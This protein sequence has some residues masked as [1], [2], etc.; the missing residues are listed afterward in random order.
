MK[1]LSLIIHIFWGLLAI[2]PKVVS[3]NIPSGTSRPAATPLPIPGAY[4]APVINY[5][6]TWE[7]IMPVT[8]AAT[9]TGTARKVQEVRQ[10]TLYT[11]GLNRPLQSVLKSASSSGKDIVLS[12]IYDGYGRQPISYLP[13]VQTDA[14]TNDGKFKSN[15]Y[16][17]QRL[18]MQ[19]A[20][21]NP[22]SKGESIFYNQ[23]VFEQAPSSS[24][25]KS[26][27]AG[28]SYA[29][30]GGKKNTQQ[31]NFVNTTTDSVRIWEIAAGIPV[32][33]KVYGAGQLTEA[34][35]IAENGSQVVEYSDKSGRIILRKVQLA[36][37]PGASHTGWLCT[38]FVYDE[39][40]KLRFV[41]PPLA[42]QHI[43]P[44]WSVTNVLAGL[45][46]IYR[47]DAKGRNIIRKLPGVDSTEMVY[48]SRDRLVLVRD[49]NLKGKASWMITYFDNLDRPVKISLY[50]SPSARD[51][52]QT[53]VDGAAPGTFPFIPVAN[54][55]DQVMFFFDDNYAFPGVQSPLTGDF[56]APQK[57]N[58]LYEIPNTAISHRVMGKMTGFKSRILGSSQWLTT[59]IYYDDKGRELQTISDNIYGGKQTITFLYDFSGK[60]LSTYLRH[61][62]PHS[63][64]TPETRILTSTNYD[65]TG[66][67]TEISTRLNDIATTNRIIASYSYDE[68]GNVKTK[69]IPKETQAIEYN[70]N[71]QL[72]AINSSFVTTAGS[73]ANWFG[74]DL[75]Y[76]YGFTTSQYDGSIA[77]VKWKSRGDGISRAFGY[78]YDCAGRIL[79]ADFAQQ[80]QGSS[81]WTADKVDF[82][83]KGLAYDGNGNI[84]GLLQKGM[85]GLTIAV[86]DSL[87]YSYIPYTNKL[88]FV[89]DKNNDPNSKLGDFKEINNNQSQD[90][91]YDAN[92][93][94][95]LDMNRLLSANR[96]N[97]LNLPDSLT[98]LG[99]GYIEFT[100]DAMGN[101]LRK[102][103]TDVSG[104][105]PVIKAYD[106]IDGFVYQND[107]LLYFPHGEGRVRATYATGKPVALVYD[108]FIA[109][110]L[111]NTRMV[112]TEET[113]LAS[114]AATMETANSAKENA[115]FS[116]ITSTRSAKPVGYPADGTT[117]PNDYVA[118]LNAGS[119]TQKIGPSLVLRVMAGDT[120][121]LG[122]KAFYKSA[123]ASTSSTTAANMLTALVQAF[124]TGTAPSDGTHGN[125]TG[126]GSPLVSNFSAANYQA[127]RD[128]DPSQNQ[129][130]LPKAYLNYVLF[131]DLLNMVD[132]NS[133]VRQVQGSPDQL[134]TLATSRIVIKK[135]GFFYVYTSNES[136]QDVFFDNI[137][138]AH[139][140]GPLLE[141]THY[142][143]FGLTMAAIS[144]K[145]LKNP[146]A[147]NRNN[148]NG[149][150]QTTE[151]GL[152]QYDAFY[153]TFD[154]QL[155]RWW[156]MDPMA[157]NYPGISPYHNNFNNPISFNDPFGDD[158]IWSFIE[159]VGWGW[160]Y[161]VLGGAVARTLGKVVVDG[162]I[163]SLATNGFIEIGN[164]ANRQQAW[165][166]NY[167][168]QK[169]P[170]KEADALDAPIDQQFEVANGFPKRQFEAYNTTPQAFRD[171]IAVNRK[172]FI[173]VTDYVEPLV[174]TVTTMGLE[175][176]FITGVSRN[177]A[178]ATIIAGRNSLV[179]AN[180]T[181]GNAFRD[182]LAE[183]LKASGRTVEKE[184]Y[185]WTPF[186]KRYIDI[187]VSFQ[188]K[189]LGGIETKVG[190]SRYKTLQRLKD[191]YLFTAKKYRVDLVRKPA[192]W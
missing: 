191:W 47:Y 189:L 116:N 71:G 85:K 10:S 77:G 160:S 187:E 82:S 147:E 44:S 41:I 59:T 30:E 154:P 185:H 51:V 36:A 106:Y 126:P 69:T 115:L 3:Q 18:F 72:K 104:S 149:I 70:I 112:L 68:M 119:G 127:I 151:L 45:C 49:G 108:Y 150:E 99:K 157:G 152:N 14:V 53:S 96:Y 17:S 175:S 74:E 55:S 138:V 141:E 174:T 171:G 110:H 131:D 12:L 133:G 183:L 84:S 121:Q 136:V 31:Y 57:G 102:K 182:E 161:P 62:N 65:S 148:F 162:A 117:S 146:Y 23:A 163:K 22:A 137:V 79:K 61:T 155:G 58:N 168:L 125:G 124:A 100:Y 32:T 135:D 28:N 11:D 164:Y 4:V 153:R 94:L 19:N 134:Q 33:T 123:A 89:T 20:V 76:D 165:K 114:Y 139:N 101:R 129:P 132:E 105:T 169:I 80:N 128:K 176:L 38:Y 120:I 92:G 184:V 190:A 122:A 54:L 56:S 166:R 167:D 75:A 188:G 24:V 179:Q 29:N 113:N 87:K 40:N 8:D 50:S 2:A 37:I 140:N 16:N 86:I 173:F 64:V 35:S 21:L 81:T 156:Q 158:P 83:V 170:I 130:T 172:T 26:Y 98:V 15:P 145:A 144:S 95:N 1:K 48:D 73:T 78:A 25:I 91:A 159:G 9:A 111:G 107:T 43:Y 60:V 143:P 5:I 181:A 88:F 103:I 142:Y 67:V 42:V 90:Y 34:V 13:Y 186:G 27:L 180:R 177:V 192:N 63:T 66:R 7:P 93:N 39:L 46:T 52:L 6:R 178:Q 97:Y 109:D 118:R